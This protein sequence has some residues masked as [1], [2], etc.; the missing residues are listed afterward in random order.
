MMRDERKSALAALKNVT[1]EMSA[2]VLTRRGLVITLPRGYLSGPRLL[3]KTIPRPGDCCSQNQESWRRTNMAPFICP[4]ENASSGRSDFSTSEPSRHQSGRPRSP[5]ADRA[6]PRRVR[7]GPLRLPRFRV[8]QG[9]F[10]GPHHERPYEPEATPGHR[11]SG[12]LTLAASEHPGR[13]VLGRPGRGVELPADAAFRGGGGD[14]VGAVQ[15]SHD[16]GES[17]PFDD[18]EDL[19]RMRDRHLGRPHRQGELLLPRGEGPPP[20]GPQLPAGP[21]PRFDGVHET[22]RDHVASGADPA[23]RPD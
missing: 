10:E 20:H 19:P 6:P 7:G 17:A 5:V 1:M 8:R 23:V 12:R 16:D 11:D 18:R 9:R 4:R 2:K 13:R 3:S 15:P 14:D 22:A 21:R